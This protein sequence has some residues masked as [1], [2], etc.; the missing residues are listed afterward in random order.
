MAAQALLS[1]PP[2]FKSVGEQNPPPQ[3]LLLA[4][5]GLT[6]L[7]C[8]IPESVTRDNRTGSG[9]GHWLRLGDSPESWAVEPSCYEQ[10]RLRYGS[11]NKI[12]KL[13]VQEEEST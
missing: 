11:S 6:W 7:W 10:K 1:R 4:P 3:S 2:L 5:T 12:Q 9:L 8:P 13:L